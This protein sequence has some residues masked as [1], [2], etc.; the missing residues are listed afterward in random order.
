MGIEAA[1]IGQRPD[2]S[3][4][5]GFRLPLRRSERARPMIQ[6]EAY[7]TIQHLPI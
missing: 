4:A 6:G 2:A 3:V 5:D 1:G 7:W